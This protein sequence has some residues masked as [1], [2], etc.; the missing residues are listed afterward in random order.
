MLIF[1][2][3]RQEVPSEKIS[4]DVDFKDYKPEDFTAPHVL[5]ATWADP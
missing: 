4:W 5:K 3:K 1:S 2:K